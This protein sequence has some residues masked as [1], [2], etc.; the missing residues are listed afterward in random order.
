[1]ISSEHDKLNIKNILGRNI[2]IFIAGNIPDQKTIE[3]KEKTKKKNTLKL[4][5]VLRIC[6]L[7]NIK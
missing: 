5:T 1:M 3:F 4:V 2:E 7:K 6:P